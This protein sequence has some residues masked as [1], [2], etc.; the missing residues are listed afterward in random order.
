MPKSLLA[1]V[2]I[3]AGLPAP[4]AAQEPSLPKYLKDRGTGIPTSLFGTYIGRGQLLVFPFYAYTRDH[5]R[6]YQPAKLGYGLEEDFRGRFQSSQQQLFLGY[7]VTD[8]L[9]LELEAS[10]ITARLDKSPGDPSAMPARLRASG[11]ADI[12]GNVRLRLM[13]EGERR[14]EFFGFLELTPRSQ[15]GK[16]LIAEPHWDVKPGVGVIRGF[17]WG[18]L[19]LRIAAEWNREAGSPDLGEIGIEYL[20]RLSPALRLNLGLEGGETGTND[21]WGVVVGLHWRVTRSLALK[22]DNAIGL[23]SKATDLESQLG[24]MFSLPR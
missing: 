16:P 23:M 24:L 13:K 11:L 5:N 3:A 19:Q 8:W 4:A 9:V 22:L 6:E 15:R 17:S 2:L 7:G 18:T 10:Y 20:K 21:E 12:E 1:A 14:P